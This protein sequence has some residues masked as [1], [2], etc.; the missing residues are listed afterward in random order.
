[1]VAGEPVGVAL[2][3]VRPRRAGLRT[4]L[5]TMGV[6]PEGRR[7]GAGRALLRRII[8]EA[9][10]CGARTLL[11]EVL[12]RNAP[13][14]LL[15]EAQGWAPCRPGAA[16]ASARRS[17]PLPSASTPRSRISTRHRSCPRHRRWS[18]SCKRW[19]PC[20][21]RMSRLRRNWPCVERYGAARR[22]PAYTVSEGWWRSTDVGQRL[23]PHREG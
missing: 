20:A 23:V 6:V 19:A 3:A 4:R 5:A 17:W 8:D 13:A 12:A 16:R 10:A 22:P 1:Y 18:R 15:Y 21:I 2:V 14:R 11:L 9:R 7:Q